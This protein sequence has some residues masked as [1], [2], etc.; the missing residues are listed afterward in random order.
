MTLTADKNY[1]VTSNLAVLDSVTLTIEAGTTIK[2]KDNTGLSV[3]EKGRLFANGTPEKRI[4][5]T[6]TDLGTGNFNG[7]KF[8]SY[9]VWDNNS[10]ANVYKSPS[11][12]NYVTIQDLNTPTSG[13]I[14]ISGGEFRQSIVTRTTSFWFFRNICIFDK[15]TITNNNYICDAIPHNLFYTNVIRNQKARDFSEIPPIP[16]SNKRDYNNNFFSNDD[17]LIGE[18]YTTIP[19]VFTPEEPNYLG[20]SNE[21]TARSRIVDINYPGSS[22]M[23]EYDVSNMLKRPVHEAPGMVWKVVVNGYDAQDEYDM[24]PPLGVGRHKFEVYFNRQMNHSVTPMLAMGVREP[25][26]QTAISE[27][28]EWRSEIIEGDTLDIYTAYLTIRGRDNFDGVNTIYVADA[29]DDLYFPI[30]IED[31]RFHV[32]V[33]SAGS[34]S[35]GFTAEPGVGKVSLTWENPEENFDDMLGYNLYRYTL[36]DN[37]AA[38]DTIRINERLL[39]S[40]E[41]IDYDITPGTTYCYYYKVLRTSLTE[42]SPSKVVAATPRAAGMG[43]AN[44]SG[45]VDVADV[46]TEVNY[47]V[48]ANPKPFM[49]EAADINSDSNID[50]LDVVAT[51]NIILKPEESTSAQAMSTAIYTI[52]NGLLYIDCPIEL[53]GL[54]VELSGDAKATEISVLDGLNGMET[55]GNWLN[56]TDYRFLAFSLSGKTIEQGKH[57][58]LSIGDATIENIMLVDTKGNQVMAMQGEFSG[59]SSVVGQQMLLPYPNPFDVQLNVPVTIATEG[60]HKVKLCLTNLA[61]VTLLTQSATLVYGEHTLTINAG[62][63]PNGFYLLT[64]VVDDKN[65]QTVRVIKK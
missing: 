2:F 19:Q 29:L 59:I 62:A 17:L 15:G 21:A 22:S 7:L 32:N 54:Q 25:Y 1:I 38:S 10:N 46:V 44:A 12:L 50:I 28:G 58:V 53:A 57:A 30:P 20:T 47:M 37:D 11:K 40:E 35:N 18:Y 60:S 51:V 64:L 34:M 4:T 31:L 65:V 26:T 52:E 9:S 36:D 5:F 41:Y 6:K 43:D 24:L 3:S 56:D 8:G 48:G 45:N 42:N 33:Q 16:S 39:D 63:L 49:F 61:G 23:G 55:A 27:D 13:S 14:L